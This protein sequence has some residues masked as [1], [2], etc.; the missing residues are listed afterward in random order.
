[1]SY[2]HSH[3]GVMS[4]TV[5]IIVICILVYLAQMADPAI[6]STYALSLPALQQG[7]YGVLLTS[8]FMHGSIDH[9]MMNMISLWYIAETL[10][11]TMKA[12]SYILTYV[13][14][15]IVGGLAW[16][17]MAA[18]AGD[19]TSS[20]VGASGAIFGLMGAQG[21]CLIKLRHHGWDVNAAWSSW[22]G[23]LAVNLFYGLLT[24][25]IALS[26][27]VGGLVCGILMGLVFC[28]CGNGAYE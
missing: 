8:M 22:I 16:A 20:C 21:A 13:T 26:A 12:P 25:G 2:S 27:H 18:Q 28:H 11:G 19:V 7:R 23:V 17:W 1:M 4:S 6:T 24:P 15:G 3:T 10:H 5:V 14:S 9:I